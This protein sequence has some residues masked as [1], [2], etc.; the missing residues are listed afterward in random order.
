[1]LDHARWHVKKYKE[2]TLD[3]A[4]SQQQFTGL[5][6][7]LSKAERERAHSPQVIAAICLLIF[8]G[9]RLNEILKLKWDY[10]L[11]EQE[12]LRLPDS[13]TGP[14]TIHLNPAALKVLNSCIHIEGNPY[15]LSGRRPRSHLKNI[16]AAWRL[17]RKEANLEG[18]RLNDLRHSFA[19]VGTASN[20]SLPIIGGLLGHSHPATTQRYAHV[21]NDPLKQA[22][23]VIGE[24]ID[25]AL[26]G[27]K[28]QAPVVTFQRKRRGKP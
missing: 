23:Y 4:L 19:T 5:G 7:A 21:H 18:V 9:A 28:K 3:R 13:K 25:H 20:L 6:R 8:T 15:V 14:K 27:D 24:Q 17:I 2:H 16:Q 12:C 10:I 26:W 11:P 1:V 22:T